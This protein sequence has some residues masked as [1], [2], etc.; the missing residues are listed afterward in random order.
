ML[1]DLETDIN[2]I[3]LKL[4]KMQEK[5]IIKIESNNLLYDEKNDCYELDNQK[6]NRVF[7][8]ERIF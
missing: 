6:F 5:I 8:N 7:R 2:Q 4:A 1:K 3:E